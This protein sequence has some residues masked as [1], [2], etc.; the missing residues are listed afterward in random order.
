MSNITFDTQAKTK[1]EKEDIEWL[2]IWCEQTNDETLPHIGL[3]G[4]SITE[5][6]Y[7]LVK[8]ALDGVKIVQES[9][10]DTLP[11]TPLHWMLADPDECV[12][13]ECTAEGTRL[14]DNPFGVLTNE[15][16]FPFHAANVNR[17]MS[18]H[19]GLSANRLSPDLP[20]I[21]HSLG[22]GA[23]GLPGDF[24][25]ASRFVRAVFEGEAAEIEAALS[26][27]SPAVL[28]ELPVDFEEVFIST[29]EG[30]RKL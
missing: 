25:S 13:L 19:E 18:L 3:I 15:P 8:K 6:Y 11:V 22:L 20:L 4:D 9:F 16:P 14:Y 1:K 23:I 24:S 30:R 12:T 27:Y 5:G 17:Y 26:A 7:Q 29:V 28:E 10:S 2:R 21:N